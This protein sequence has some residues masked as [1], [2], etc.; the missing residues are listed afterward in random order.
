MDLRDGMLGV[1]E[2]GLGFRLEF[3]H[4]GTSC[5]LSLAIYPWATSFLS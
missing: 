4:R 3:R 5:A 1:E 2:F